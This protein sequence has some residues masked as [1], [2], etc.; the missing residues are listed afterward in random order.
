M[1]GS[2]TKVNLIGSDT[3]APNDN[4]VFSLAQDSSG[5]L[6]LRPY[7]DHLYIARAGMR[8]LFED[9]KGQS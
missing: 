2:I 8:T 9:W 6:R 1:L 3:K 5:E 7:S 4:K